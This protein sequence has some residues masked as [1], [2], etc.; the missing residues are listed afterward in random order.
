M[1][2]KFAPNDKL[3]RVAHRLIK[4]IYGI[5]GILLTNLSSLYDFEDILDEIPGHKLIKFTH[6]PEKEKKLYKN[7]D[8]TKPD[9]LLV[10]YPPLTKEDKQ[11]FWEA[12]RRVIMQRLEKYDGI[13]F[14]DYP[15]D[16][17]YV[18]E[19]VKFIIKKLTK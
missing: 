3:N 15:N 13:S 11:V 19:V 2:I 12:H 18:W 7:E 9:R 6:V 17:L 10:W 8:L 1:K 5:E 14:K 4:D 16:D